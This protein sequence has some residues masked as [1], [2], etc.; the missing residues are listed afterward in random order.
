MCLELQSGW[1]SKRRASPD[2]PKLIYVDTAAN[3][4]AATA[5]K[6][7]LVATGLLS[8][9]KSEFALILEQKG[10]SNGAFPFSN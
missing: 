7:A 3:S 9:Q 8:N 6:A 2:E 5:A 4:Y 1:R 10:P